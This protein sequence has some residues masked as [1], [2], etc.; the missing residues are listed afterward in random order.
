MIRPSNN[1]DIAI[2][3]EWLGE[4]DLWIRDNGLLGYDPFDIKQHPFIRAAQPN[5]FNRKAT[6]AL[7]DFFP[8]LLRRQLGIE[9]TENPKAHAL[10]AIGYLRL[11]QITEAPSFLERA[12]HHMAWLL[13]NA[14]EGYSG[15]C[16]GYPFDIFAK[17]LDTPKDTPVLVVSAIAGEAFHLAHEI[18]GKD[19][20]LKHAQ[21]VS[22][23]ILRDLPRM[24]EEDRFCFGYTPGDRRRVHNANLLAVEHLMRVWAVTG[25]EELREAAEPALNF[26]LKRQREDGAWF[27]GAYTAGEPF[28]QG[29]LRLIDHHHTGFVLRSLH[30]IHGIEPDD[31]LLTAITRGFQYYKRL[32]TKAGMPINQ[33]GAYPVD[34]HSCAE[35]F[36]CPAVLSETLRGTA[37]Q[38]IRTLRWT[39]AHMRNPQNGVPLYRKYPGFTSRLV[40]PRWGIAWIFRALAE[41]LYRFGKLP[42]A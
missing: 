8:N 42:V 3:Q 2:A 41:Y 29:L 38:A 27:Y 37:P 15:L 20:Y 23:F 22:Q 18:T 25:E 39:Y 4:L 32:Y 34:I 30:T 14:N 7:G 5:W 21:S 12:E 36:L 33:Y 1:P 40:C 6:T 24:E 35:G 10:V 28:E 31:R 13:A 16:W 19:D 26:T 17:G 9:M 11:Y